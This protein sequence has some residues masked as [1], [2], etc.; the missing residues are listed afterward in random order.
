[1]AIDT[2]IAIAAVV[3]PRR[4]SRRFCRAARRDA[5]WP[6][7]RLA[8]VISGWDRAQL[9]GGGWPP[10]RGMA[11]LQQ[12]SA[13]GAS[14]AI[15]T[16]YSPVATH[17]QRAAAD[18]YCE[19]LKAHTEAALAI[20]AQLIGAELPDTT[21]HFGLSLI[22]AVIEKQWHQPG[23]EARQAEIKALILQMMASASG[24]PLTEEPKF[25]KEKL[26]GLLSAVGCREWPQRWPDMFETIFQI[27]AMGHKQAEL[28]IIALRL[29]GE[30]IMEFNDNLSGG[31]RSD[32]SQALKV[33]LPQ[34]LPF[35]N[36]FAKTRFDALGAARARGAEGAADVRALI[37]LLDAALQLLQSM[38][39]WVPLQLLYGNEVVPLCC[40]L[41]SDPDTRVRACECIF[42]LAERSVDRMGKGQSG[43]PRG[44][45]EV[46]TAQ[47]EHAKAQL[48]QLVALLA[49]TPLG[50]VESLLEN[51]DAYRFAKRVS[52]LVAAIGEHQI[53]IFDPPGGYAGTPALVA[54]RPPSAELDGALTDFTRLAL[55]IAAH[56]SAAVAVS[57]LRA[58]RAM[59]R[60]DA[61]RARAPFAEALPS[62]VNLL[63]SKLP[64]VYEPAFLRADDDAGAEHVS[65]QFS[66][67]DFDEEDGFRAFY[68]VFRA[69]S[70]QLIQ[71]VTKIAPLMAMEAAQQIAT[72]LVQGGPNACCGLEAAGVSPELAQEASLTFIE[73]AMGVLPKRL[74]LP[75]EHANG[76]AAAAKAVLTQMLAYAPNHSTTVLDKQLHCLARFAPFLSYHHELLPQTMDVL[77]LKVAFRGANEQ[78]MLLTGLSVETRMLRQ[79]ACVSMTRLCKEIDPK[80]VDR[81]ADVPPHCRSPP[82]GGAEASAGLL[83]VAL[84]HAI[85]RYQELAAELLPNDESLLTEAL[86]CLSNHLQTSEE[87]SSFIAQ[88]LGQKLETW[89]SLGLV[90]TFADAA[91]FKRMLRVDA[92]AMTELVA[93]AEK[94]EEILHEIEE[95][96]RSIKRILYSL[97]NVCK[98][99][100]P[101]SANTAHPFAASLEAV[102]PAVCGLLTAIERLWTDAVQPGEESLAAEGSLLSVGEWERAQNEQLTAIGKAAAASVAVVGRSQSTGVIDPQTIR[103]QRGIAAGASVAVKHTAFLQMWLKEVREH[104]YELVAAA[105]SAQQRLSGPT[106]MQ[107]AQA[108]FGSLCAA[109]GERVQNRHLLSMMRIVVEPML[110]TDSNAPAPEVWQAVCCP[111]LGMFFGV[112]V[113]RLIQGWGVLSAADAEEDDPWVLFEHT[114]IRNLGNRAVTSLHSCLPRIEPLPNAQPGDALSPLLHRL[115]MGNEQ[116]T[117]MLLPLLASSLGCPDGTTAWKATKVLLRA[118]PH[119]SDNPATQPYVDQTLLMATLETLVE[120]RNPEVHTEL[121][122]LVHE[123]YKKRAETTVQTLRSL[124]GVP[125]GATEELVKQLT[126]AAN[127]SDGKEKKTARITLKD[128]LKVCAGA[129]IEQWKRPPKI[130]S[131]P[132][133]LVLADPDPGGLRAAAVRALHTSLALACN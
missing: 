102:L 104:C 76:C 70:T 53:T 35:I 36:D 105:F 97:V 85:R 114:I 10:P 61:V 67:L 89:A 112:V 19:Q 111:A 7:P 48:R 41:V 25:I 17:E 100:R 109:G 38:C 66:E 132:E 90:E 47:I 101:V 94:V 123:I 121:L 115:L 68:G 127:C 120:G 92:L 18:L 65:A 84:P 32:L 71:E 27:A 95:P 46:T 82:P 51:E 133:T 11:A 50:T 45:D 1:M 99:V 4:H 116:T 29:V 16:I 128:F 6:A 77:L 14:Q 72:A 80:V 129:K 117:A 21:R 131:L 69:A 79:R 52:Q 73:Q 13:E 62:L 5:E 34:V 113:Q 108:A 23:F 83:R 59:L 39:Q 88:L 26:C 54:K 49:A 57:P 96:I 75:S 55:S 86:L 44:E 124:P 15:A 43:K 118:V 31:R 58:L 126:K 130:V 78:G 81:E 37:Q 2:P 91:S 56:P 30:E 8:G 42:L 119:L 40:A 3:H 125:P 24:K 63:L 93:S 106:V 9:D 110:G 33:S 64:R 122:N 60:N 12:F 20:S 87:R 74:F 103:S 22:N 28:A 98:R 107:V